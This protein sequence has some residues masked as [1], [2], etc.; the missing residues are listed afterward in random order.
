MWLTRSLEACASR[1]DMCILGAP[2]INW[3]V[4][5]GIVSLGVA[6]VVNIGKMLWNTVLWVIKGAIRLLSVSIEDVGETCAETR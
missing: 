6:A 1:F 4:P 5:G 2:Q 3:D